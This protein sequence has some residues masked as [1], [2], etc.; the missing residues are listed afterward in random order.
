MAIRWG[1]LGAG[2]FADKRP[3]P[4]LQNADNAKIEAIMVRDLDRA[5]KLADKYKAP[6]YYDNVDSF[7]KDKDIDAVYICTPVY[8]HK[9]Q[10]IKAACKGK[11]ILCEKPMALNRNE[12]E[13]MIKICKKNKVKFM[14]AFML[15]FHTSLLKIKA[16]IEQGAL[17]RII[18]ARAQLYLWYPDMSGAWRQNT[19]LGGGGCLMDLG[20]HCL[21]LLCFLF[22]EVEAVSAMKDTIAFNYPVE[23]T[24]HV[25]IKFKNKVQAMMDLAFSIPSR[26]NLLELYGTKG[27]ILCRKVIGP[28]KDPVMRLITEKGEEDISVPY[29][30]T[31]QA[32]FSHFSECLTEEKEPKVTAQEGLYNL[33]LIQAIY[34]AAETKK[35]VVIECRK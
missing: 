7:L 34:R 12:A 26:E 2:G 14:P 35:E 6:K 22:G 27:T 32:E 9:E 28:F 33:E 10:T 4:G 18:S 31:Y 16:L 19:K 15:R 21:D 29:E 25:L 17:G 24:I 23:D 5:K 3:L 1:V 20:P 8:L 30:D 13:E 11:H